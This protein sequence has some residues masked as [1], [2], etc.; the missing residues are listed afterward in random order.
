MVCR[1]T[2]AR[3]YLAARSSK[4]IAGS[5]LSGFVACFFRSSESLCAG[6]AA[7]QRNRISIVRFGTAL[8]FVLGSER[9]VGRW[10]D[11][12][13]STLSLRL[14]LSLLLYVFRQQQKSMEVPSFSS[15][16]DGGQWFRSRGVGRRGDAGDDGREATERALVVGSKRCVGVFG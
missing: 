4:I 14:S 9:W 2:H 12:D 8:L 7:G 16:S 1:N 6:A 15:I 3:S 13:A 10:D 5:R 11:D